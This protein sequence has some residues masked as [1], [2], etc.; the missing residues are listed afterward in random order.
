MTHPI[1]EQIHQDLPD[2]V[3]VTTDQ[4]AL[5]VVHQE[6]DLVAWLKDQDPLPDNGLEALTQQ[7]QHHREQNGGTDE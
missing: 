6:L 5:V 2:D 7:V 4:V 1:V 3:D